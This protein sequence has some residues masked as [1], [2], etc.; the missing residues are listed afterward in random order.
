MHANNSSRRALN[1]RSKRKDAKKWGSSFLSFLRE[2]KSAL[3]KWCRFFFSG[4]TKDDP[5]KN[6]P[7]FI[8]GKNEKFIIAN[9][10]SKTVFAIAY[11]SLHL[12]HAKIVI[13]DIRLLC[14]YIARKKHSRAWRIHS[15]IDSRR[16]L[17]NSPRHWISSFRE[18]R[19]QTIYRGENSLLHRNS[20]KAHTRM[21]A[22]VWTR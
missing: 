22:G 21:V 16:L 20:E 2:K 10:K 12:Y 7:K 6:K 18:A 3:E 17:W 5:R 4:T 15:L 13:I 8:R 19:Q 11:P 1:S 9:K 14:P